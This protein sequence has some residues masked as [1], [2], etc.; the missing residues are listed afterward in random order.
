MYLKVIARSLQENA[1][2]Q[3]S[4]RIYALF[5][6][7]P[8]IVILDI[9]D[10]QLRISMSTR[11]FRHLNRLI[12]R[13]RL[14][15]FLIT[16]LALLLIFPFV[17]ENFVGY[18]VILEMF[19]SL[20]LI[21]GIYIV[22]ANR[23][24]LTISILLGTLALTVI[25]FNL[26]LNNERLLIFGL[27]LLIAF[28]ALTTTTILMHVLSYK[29]VTADKIYGAICGYLLIG[30]NWALVYTALEIAFPDSFDMTQN[31]RAGILFVTYQPIYLSHFLYY[32]FITL[33][34]TGFGDI[35]PL[36]NIARAL[37]SIEAVVGQLYV[38]VLI[39]R[40]VGLHIG[41]TIM[42]R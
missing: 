32:S 38:A 24:V 21:A 31:L 16:L 33:T 34:T 12:L 20:I 4:Q 22:S 18:F 10:K 7:R 28:F 6:C 37:S 19:I 40:L 2:R 29:R 15:I 9:F 8:A 36:S 3:Q 30:I 17:Q 42:K 1:S 11:K 35:A 14:L 23:Q 5:R 13:H 41:H 39:A 27:L 26:F 25:W